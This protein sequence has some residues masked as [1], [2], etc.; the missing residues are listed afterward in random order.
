M[1]VCFGEQTERIA[2]GVI[3]LLATTW[4]A[5]QLYAFAT[6][7]DAASPLDFPAAP[8]GAT[9]LVVTHTLFGGLAGDVVT[10]FLQ[11]A[12]M[13]AAML[14]PAFLM[15][16][17]H[18]G[19]VAA[20]ASFHAQGLSFASPGESWVARAELWLIPIAGT[21]ASQEALAR[22]RHTHPTE[23]RARTLIVRQPKGFTALVRYALNGGERSCSR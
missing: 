11:G 19:I 12:I 3:A 22:G 6:I 1:R 17:A 14:V 8:A 5:A 13:V 21:V 15:F 20:V 10:D 7:I 16:D 23:P 18:G 2:A 4:S 9:A